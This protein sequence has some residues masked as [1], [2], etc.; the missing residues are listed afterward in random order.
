MTLVGDIVGGAV[1][2]ALKEV[3]KQTGIGKRARRR[4]R[5]TAASRLRA[6]EK[7]VLPAKQQ[8]SRKRTVRTRSK[9][10]R[11]ST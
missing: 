11:R 2:S 10:W 8:K 3:L 4:K 6:I 7:L 1:E 9:A 5:S